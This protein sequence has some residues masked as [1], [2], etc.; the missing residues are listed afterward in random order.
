MEADDA[1]AVG[2]HDEVAA[3]GFAVLELV[4]HEVLEVKDFL[5]ALV[6][7]VPDVEDAGMFGRAYANGDVHTAA[8]DAGAL[9]YLL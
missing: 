4:G 7:K 8:N 9:P 1:G 6:A 2:V 3:V 5:E